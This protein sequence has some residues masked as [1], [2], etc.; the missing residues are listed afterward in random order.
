MFFSSLFARNKAGLDSSLIFQKKLRNILG[1]KT[2]RTSIYIKALTHRSVIVHS[3]PDE[4]N[5][6]LEFLGDAIIGAIVADLLYRKF[7]EGDEG[8][9]TRARSR[10]VK[11]EFLNQQALSL[12]LDQLIR[13]HSSLSV[14]HQNI[15]GNALEAFI[16]AIFIDKGYKTASRFVIEKILEADT[17]FNNSSLSDFELQVG[18]QPLSPKNILNEWAQ[19]QR[20]P[21][22]F[23]TIADPE[24]TRVFSSSLILND[25]AIAEGSGTTKKEAEQ[26]AAKH[27]LIKLGIQE[28]KI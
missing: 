17:V 2:R 12:K 23:Q 4:N 8:L 22:I 14:P 25:A 19:K 18:E 6:R 5:E 13:L 26:N 1:F 11:R 28:P 21:Y 20:V 9:L 3:S 24:N 7:P 10:F 27:A 15:Y 16:G